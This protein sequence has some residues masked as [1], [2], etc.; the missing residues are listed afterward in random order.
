MREERQ[1]VQRTLSVHLAEPGNRAAMVYHL[2]FLSL[3]Y[4]LETAFLIWK[5]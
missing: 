5:D 1:L 4:K 3:I 2:A